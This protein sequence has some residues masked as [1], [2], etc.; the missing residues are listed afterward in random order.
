MFDKKNLLLTPEGDDW[1]FS[2]DYTCACAFLQKYRKH[3]L[4]SIEALHQ[5]LYNEKYIV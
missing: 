4:E 3:V 5:F 2:I 1:P